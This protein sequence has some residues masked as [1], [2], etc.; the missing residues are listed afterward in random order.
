MRRYVDRIALIQLQTPWMCGEL[1]RFDDTRTPEM[2]IRA[3]IINKLPKNKLGPITT[4]YRDHTLKSVVVNH[5]A[6]KAA[7]TTMS[8]P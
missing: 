7:I 3:Q 2:D 6:T 5:C 1:F 4:S 8:K